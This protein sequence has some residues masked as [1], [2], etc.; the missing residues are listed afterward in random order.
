M[1]KLENDGIDMDELDFAEEIKRTFLNGLNQIQICEYF[2]KLNDNVININ[3]ILRE[4]SIA[5]RTGEISRNPQLHGFLFEKLHVYTFNAKAALAHKN[6]RA[7]VLPVDGG[8]FGKNSVDISIRELGTNKV[9]RNYQ[10]K[11]CKDVESTV[12]AFE[13]GNYRNQ[14]YLVCKNQVEDVKQLSSSGKSVGDFI[15]YDGIR[16]TPQKYSEVKEIQYALQSGDFENVDLSM[17]SAQELTLMGIEAVGKEVC[18]DAILRVVILVINHA[19]LH[20]KTGIQEDIVFN[21]KELG[22]DAVKCFI[23]TGLKSVIGTKAKYLPDFLKNVS[24]DQIRIITCVSSELLVDVVRA[25]YNYHVGKY[26][27]VEAST[28]IVRSVIKGVCA[29]TGAAIAGVFTEGVGV[30]VGRILGEMLGEVILYE[31]GQER[32]EKAV[33]GCI[34][35]GNKG[36]EIYQ[37][38]IDEINKLFT[39]KEKVV[40][41]EGI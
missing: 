28:L 13:Q 4:T 30:E 23:N 8:G 16:S 39:T 7:Y 2:K 15:E 31:I 3:K 36:K 33:Q 25:G 10:A 38:G 35:L 37:I 18:V 26:S 17:W 29:L 1:E 6:F 22:W 40:V 9:L 27:D 21:A 5:S 24:A 12:K 14:R 41:M 19:L 34:A 32:L 20:T 11:C